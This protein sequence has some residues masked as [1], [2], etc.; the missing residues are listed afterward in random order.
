MHA[1]LLH[2][3]HTNSLLF[4][5]SNFWVKICHLDCL[6]FLIGRTIHSN[7]FMKKEANMIKADFWWQSA[8]HLYSLDR[9]SASQSWIWSPCW[10]SYFSYTL[11]GRY[12]SS[13]PR[14]MKNSVKYFPY[15]GLQFYISMK[16]EL[17]E[18]SELKLPLSTNRMSGRNLY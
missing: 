5:N 11:S 4:C 16:Q 6:K 8:Q 13:H 7:K 3:L 17:L 10:L 1:Y 12:L 2:L 14:K 15:S 9:H 18:E